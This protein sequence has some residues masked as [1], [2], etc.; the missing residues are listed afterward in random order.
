V[1]GGGHGSGGGQF[2]EVGSAGRYSDGWGS[3]RV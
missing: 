3:V 1:P 2:T